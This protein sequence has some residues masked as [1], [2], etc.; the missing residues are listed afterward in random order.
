MSEELA[1]VRIE[2]DRLYADPKA[3]IA[4]KNELVRA[5]P[6]ISRALKRAELDRRDRA[7]TDRDIAAEAMWKERQGDEYGSY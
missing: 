5:W 3:Y 4:L 2:L 7:E 6:M 1:R